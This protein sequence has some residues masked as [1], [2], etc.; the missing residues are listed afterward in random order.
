[1]G[2]IKSAAKS[3]GSVLGDQWLDA[4]RCED[5]GN[6][7]LM[8][9][10]SDAN[11]RDIISKKSTIIVNPGQLAL[12]V[13][14]GKVLDGTAEPGIF[15]FDQSSS[16][17]F[18]GG[19]FGPV[20]KEMWQRFKYGGGISKQQAV[21][22]FNAKEIINNKFGTATPVPYS[23][24]GHPTFNPRTQALYGMAVHIR[25]YGIYSFR[26]SNPFDFLNRISGNA[27]IYTKE[28]LDAQMRSELLASLQSALNQLGTAEHK[29]PALDLPGNSEELL[30][31]IRGERFDS[32]IVERGVSILS[33]AI[34]SVSFDEDS[35]KKIDQ[36]ELSD[37]LSQAGYLAHAQGEALKT[38]AGNPSG[39][40]STMMGMGIGFGSMGVNP[41]SAMNAAGG[42]SSQMQ[43]GKEIA[44]LLDQNRAGVW[45][46]S[47]GKENS[48]KF[49]AECGGK[50]PEENT[51]KC[52]CGKENSG[53]FCP[54][55]G[56]K[57]PEAGASCRK[58]GADLLNNEKFCP[59]C[60]E[61]V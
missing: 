54:E 6:D 40:G 2:L 41:M 46:C 42:Q 58:C 9:R 60:G 11:G 22:F 53:K 20:F 8:K 39:G 36:Y 26:I 56:G 25:M 13:D 34:Q 45:T 57:K 7:I 18:F 49:C 19:D 24:W 35:K 4:I 51:W 16:P 43:T 17:S 48:G 50:K 44:D 10:V 30:E 12:I 23:D 15:T 33:I 38:A 55:C 31:L 1:M 52:A 37:P 28:E 47:C 21:Y 32:A 3:V 29:I 27:G 14:N 5:L 61:K 59:E